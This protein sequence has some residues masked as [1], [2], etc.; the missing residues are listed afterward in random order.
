MYSD[1][2]EKT[3]LFGYIC[4]SGRF[5]SYDG[6]CSILNENYISCPKA[7]ASFMYLP[8]HNIGCNL[9]LLHF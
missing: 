9:P 4:L 5:G 7:I 2:L 6:K 8:K 1:L 3:V